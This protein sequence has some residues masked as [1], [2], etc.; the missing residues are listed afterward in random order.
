[1]NGRQSQ[2]PVDPQRGGATPERSTGRTKKQ[3][4]QADATD[5]EP[6]L[7]DGHE[8]CDE[9][10]RCEVDEKPENEDRS[11]NLSDSGRNGWAKLAG[12]RC[13]LDGFRCSPL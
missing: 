5:D 8:R 13:L 11:N 2:W 12:G 7:K 4:Q 6:A 1:M 3:D 9:H 10:H